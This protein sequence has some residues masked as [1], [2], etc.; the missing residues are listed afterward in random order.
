MDQV[1][2]NIHVIHAPEVFRM[3]DSPARTAKGKA[4][5]S[6]AVGMELIKSGE[7][8]AIITAG[9]TGGAMANA[10]FRLGRI[11]G[12][13]RPG[14]SIALPVQGG[15]ATLIDIGANTDCRPIYLLQFA[16]LGSVYAEIALNKTSP[17]VGLVS[18]GEEPGKGNSLVKETYPLLEESGLNFVGNIEP[19]ELFA[20]EAD[21][22]V[23]DGFTG[24]VLVKSA[25]AVSKMMGN[26]IRTE[27][28]ASPV[29]SIGGL[30]ARPAFQRVGLTLD[31]GEYGAAPLL[32]VKGLVFIGHGRSDAKA[33]Y[34]A[35]RVTRDAVAGNLLQALETAISE[36]L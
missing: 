31:P 21:V 11:R 5:S 10:L 14:L 32:G 1:P 4:E 24:N 33:V 22:A 9:N 25:E 7:A 23:M 3:T 17:R 12:V 34:N 19:K 36:R 26:L 27:I 35:I 13:K 2:D 15:F 20:G 29:S 30:L 8:D 16:V 18:N 6:M 28:K